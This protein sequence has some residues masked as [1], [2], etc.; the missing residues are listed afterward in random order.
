MENR[1]WG[2]DGRDLRD[3]GK[4][5]Y[6]DGLLTG[7]RKRISYERPETPTAKCGL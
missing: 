4:G 6:V 5:S 2:K 3:E 7:K 1:Q